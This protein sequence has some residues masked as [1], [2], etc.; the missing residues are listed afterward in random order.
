MSVPVLDIVRSWQPLADALTSDGTLRVYPSDAP[1]DATRPLIVYSQTDKQPL[2]PFAHA[3]DAEY[4]RIAFD[5]WATER[6]DAMHIADMLRDAFDHYLNGEPFGYM[7]SGFAEQFD[8][9][10]RAFVVGFDWGIWTQRAGP[11]LQ[12]P[13][14]STT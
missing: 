5:C 12:R 11:P 7:A 2:T 6:D 9:E 4:N 13:S 3:P 14:A 10:S 1:H 8:P